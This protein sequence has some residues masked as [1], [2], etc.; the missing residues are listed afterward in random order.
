M[1]NTSVQTAEFTVALTKLGNFKT[2]IEQ[3]A[4]ENQQIAGVYELVQTAQK[5]VEENLFGFDHEYGV[6]A[7][8]NMEFE[9]IAELLGR[10]NSCLL[11]EGL[12]RLEEADHRDRENYNMLSG[13]DDVADEKTL[14]DIQKRSGVL[15]FFENI[16]S[17][18]NGK[19]M[20]YLEPIQVAMTQL[21]D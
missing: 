20:F 14:A 21:F 18:R 4:T 12:Y 10:G 9:L 19:G 7:C 15:C 2:A 11:Q 17:I 1:T 6:S 3:L 8:G 5:L 16:V 13:Y